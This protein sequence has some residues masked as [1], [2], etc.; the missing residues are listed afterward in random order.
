[1]SQNSKMAIKNDDYIAKT[2]EVKGIVQGVGFRPFVYQLANKYHL[3]GNVANTPDGVLINVEG[4]TNRVD[5]F[6][7]DIHQKKPPLA[8]LTSI[9]EK[10]KIVSGLENF[11]ILKSK[12]KSFRSTLISPDISICDDCRKEL[13]DSTDRRYGYPFINCTNC[14]PRYTIIDDIPYDRKNTSMKHFKM[15]EP[16]QVEYDDPGNRRFHAQP[17]ACKTCGPGV[18]L[19]DKNKNRI[20]TDNPVKTAIEF[21]KAGHI[22]AI[23]GLGGFHLAADAENDQAVSVLRKRK[24]RDEKPF[25]IMSKDIHIINKYAHINL[26]EKNLLHAI[27]KPIVIIKQKVPNT[28]SKYVAPGNGYF[29]VMLP[30]TPLHCLLLESDVIFN[31]YYFR[32]NSKAH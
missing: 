16:C 28:L 12:S 23:K 13:F 25:A 29:G 31:F 6:C 17:N 4:H 27:Q 21:L 3:N 30:Y 2:L 8:H 5:S 18:S 9:L 11:S 32:R 24:H 10:S 1:L 19:F 15:C 20:Q 14:G 7:K 26:E 22:I